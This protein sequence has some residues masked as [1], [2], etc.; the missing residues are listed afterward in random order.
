[1][2]R[3]DEIWIFRFKSCFAR[4]SNACIRETRPVL[5]GKVVLYVKMNKEFRRR[6]WEILNRRLKNFKGFL[7]ISTAAYN[8]TAFKVVKIGNLIFDLSK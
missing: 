7:N 6:F 5:R 8:N 4:K 1:M 2:N 3:N